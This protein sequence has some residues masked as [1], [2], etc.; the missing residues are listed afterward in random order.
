MSR[1]Y[2]HEEHLLHVEKPSIEMDYARLEVGGCSQT[3]R[4]TCPETLGAK[5]SGLAPKKKSHKLALN[6]VCH[7]FQA[8]VRVQFLIDMVQMVPQGLQRD[9]QLARNFARILAHR[10]QLQDFSLVFGKRRNGSRSPGNVWNTDQLARN[11]SHLAEQFLVLLLLGD[12][13]RQL[14]DQMPM[15][16]EILVYDGGHAHP[17]STP[18]VGLHFQVKV[19]DVGV[20]GGTVP[21]AAIIATDMGS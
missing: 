15:V 8:V 9:P 2:L 1:S 14:H 6:R 16:A 4:S 5:K 19:W 7:R 21:N 18:R 11:L 10:K 3:K 17:H 13:M 12:V 20:P